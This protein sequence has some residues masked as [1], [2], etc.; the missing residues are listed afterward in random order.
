MKFVPVTLL[1]FLLLFQVA[2]TAGIVYAEEFID[3]A[4]Q[5]QWRETDE[6][7]LSGKVART[8]FWG[9]QPF[10][11]T[12]EVYEESP[13]NGQRQ[14]Q[15]FD[16]ARMEL[17]KKTGQPENYVTNGLLTVEMVSGRLQ[18]GD[19]RFLIREPALNPVA[20]D[21]LYNDLSPTYAS[22]NKGKLA[23]GVEGTA[24]AVDRTGQHVLEAMD[25][26]GNVSTLE[27]T[28]A[29]IHYSRY[30]PI[31]GHNLADVFDIFFL[32]EP[33]GVDKWLSVMGYPVSEPF[34]AKD[35]VVV[36]G[37]PRDVLIQLFERRVL[38][39]TPSNPKGWQVEMGNIGQHYYA[40]RYQIDPTAGPLPGNY[41][42]IASQGKVLWSN[43]LAKQEPVKLGELSNNI[44]KIKPSAKGQ[45]LVGA[46]FKIYLFDLGIPGQFKELPL[47]DKVKN[48]TLSE[49]SW[50]ADGKSVTVLVGS[51]RSSE[52]PDGSY[53][54][55]DKAT[56]LFYRLNGMDVVGPE[57]IADNL[58]E[59]GNTVKPRLSPD[60]HYLAYNYKPDKG[61][62]VNIHDLS[63]GPDRK[64][65]LA[66]GVEGG[67]VEWVGKTNTLMISPTVQQAEGQPWLG[68]VMLLNPATGGSKTLLENELLVHGSVSPDGNYLAVVYRKLLPNVA[69]DYLKEMRFYRL[70]DVTKEIAPRYEQGTGGRYY[71]PA[72][73]MGWGGDGT[74]VTLQTSASGTAGA[75]YRD[76]GLV[77]LVTGKTIRKFELRYGY[78]DQ[79]YVSETGPHYVLNATG[80]MRNP[81]EN[82]VDQEISVQNLDGSN[83]VK[84]FS[85]THPNFELIAV[86]VVPVPPR[87]G[88]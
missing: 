82:L 49:A 43:P 47:G 22:F 62:T 66:T 85:D 14:V 45:A 86:Q 78:L 65:E 17:S 6:A 31:T 21:P 51:R 33:L 52:Y 40:W 68:K 80:T 71:N 58:I 25:K 64:Y 38:T 63:G 1:S 23:F 20:G 84:L 19:N 3:P 61:M 73:L 57:L 70:E 46:G 5:Q 77:S 67:N 83:K 10:A 42:V 34:W 74:Y 44:Y 36:A 26:S 24:K 55:L 59:Y 88:K 81:M 7:V 11:H 69:G 15:Y 39:F 53:Y 4:F 32:K 76:I 2:G 79:V 27:Q 87:T 72:F 28:P 30:Y 48:A 12:T 8:F 37:Q 60:A 29:Q 16:K 75:Q 35:K 13:N 9:P 41:Q 50:S 18:A 54:E 56:L